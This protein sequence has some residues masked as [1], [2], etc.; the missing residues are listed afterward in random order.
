AGGLMEEHF[1]GPECQGLC[2]GNP[3][4]AL[5]GR[6]LG[7]IVGDQGPPSSNTS[8]MME[9]A[10]RAADVVAGAVNALFDGPVDEYREALRAAGYTPLDIP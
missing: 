9:Q 6:P 7:R 1:T 3:T 8:I 10:Q 4:A 2:R 5:V